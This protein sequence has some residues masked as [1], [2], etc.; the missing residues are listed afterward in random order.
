M[1]PL[2]ISRMVT[3]AASALLGYGGAVLSVGVA[4]GAATVLRHYHL[5]HPFTSF[6]FAAI[7][8]TFWCAGTAPGMFAL[9][10]SY[11]AMT[12][13]WM[14]I[15]IGSSAS[16]SLLLIYAVFGLFVSWFSSSR[17]RAERLLAE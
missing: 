16:D 9:L 13:L 6:S 2:G 8:I 5:A 12:Y 10:L 1:A 3:R 17:R 15:R 14:P 4:L 7:A 11:F